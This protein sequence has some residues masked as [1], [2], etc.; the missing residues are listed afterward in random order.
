MLKHHIL[1]F[2]DERA[3]RKT[4]SRVLCSTGAH[5]QFPETIEALEEA[6]PQYNWSL[7]IMDVEAHRFLTDKGIDLQ[8]QN[9]VIL[10]SEKLKITLPYLSNIN[11]FT[12]FIAKNDTQILGAELLA[13]TKKILH[14][15]IF[16]V[17]KDMSIHK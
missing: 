9:I 2:D 5:C 15:D 10:S 11:T 13:T 8:D 16:G 4:A 7:I 14:N 3:N 12:N 6:L 1:F 17:Q